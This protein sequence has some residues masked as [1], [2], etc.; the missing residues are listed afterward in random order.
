MVMSLSFPKPMLAASH[1][2]AAFR[3]TEG[4]VAL[5]FV[6]YKISPEAEPQMAA[7]THPASPANQRGAGLACMCGEE[8][9]IV[10]DWVRDDIRALPN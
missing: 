2:T 3:S 4:I 1:L 7:N 9:R 6:I 5:P 10:S 8:G